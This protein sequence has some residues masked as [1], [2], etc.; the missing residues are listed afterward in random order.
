MRKTLAI[1]FMFAF[2]L[3]MSQTAFAQAKVAPLKIKERAL[4]NGL[5]V[6][7]L[8][9]NSSP[10]V[11]VQVWFDVG[12]KNDPE[13][14]NGFAHLFEHLMFKS[15]KNLK[16]EQMDRLTEDVGGNNNA[17]TSDDVTNYF[18]NIPSNYLETLLWAEAERMVNLNVDEANFKSERAVVQEE[19][20]QSVLAQPYGQFYEAIQKLSFN[21]HPYKRTTIGTIEDLQAATL[22]DVQKFYK[23]F[24]RPDNATLIVVG[25]FDQNQLDT[26]VDKYFG[27]ISKR[28]EKIPRVSEIEPER[29]AEKRQTVKAPNVP[30]PAV[31]ITYLA[32]NAK[33][34]DIAALKIAEAILS[35]GESSR[36]YQELVYKQQI[37]QEADFSVDEH[38]DKGLMYFTATLASGKTPEMA[39]KSL[40]AELKKMQDAPVSAKELEKAKN[41]IVANAIRSLET[42]QGKAFAIGQAVILK[43]A[44]KAVN[45]EINE[46]QAV[47][48]ADVQRVMKQYFKDNNRVVIY[49]ENEGETK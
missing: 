17:S 5:K 9:D 31:A 8:Q 29:R 3:F 33:S 13:G 34:K 43:G 12:S 2:A 45:D 28:S 10:S 23:T 16:S 6:V 39:E 36:L 47:T 24:Y 4:M 18:E 44:A 48:A 41:T 19:F 40:L 15:T 30:L 46:L 27:R 14:R 26:W 38:V 21:V 37:A 25:D 42:N 1:L 49:Y 20:R 22:E 35:N 7:S 11:T 32:P